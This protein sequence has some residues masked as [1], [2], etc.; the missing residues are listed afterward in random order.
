[1]SGAEVH[2]LESVACPGA[3]ACGGQ[4]TA[5]TMSMAL[6]FLGICPAGLNG[7][8]ALHPSKEE[9]AYEAGVLAMK[10]VRDDIRPS[11][12]ITARGARQRR[13]VDRRQRRLDE[14]RAAPAR[15]RTRSSASRT[16][17]RTSTPS[18]RG[19]PWWRASSPAA[20]SWRPTSMLRAASRSS[21]ASC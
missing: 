1:M 7:I 15:D 4:F 19:R 9:A 6:D 5:N 20:A 21:P 16:R 14:R 8:P 3:G 18:P 13:G 2:A 12:I 11:Q 10:L 17:S